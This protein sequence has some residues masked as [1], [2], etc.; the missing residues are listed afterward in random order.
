MSFGKK[1]RWLF[2]ALSALWRPKVNEGG[3][4]YGPGSLVNED[5]L[6]SSSVHRARNLVVCN[7][8]KFV[9]K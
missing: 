3:Q 4:R 5:F 2:M 7:K 8:Q 6:F 1:D 9:S